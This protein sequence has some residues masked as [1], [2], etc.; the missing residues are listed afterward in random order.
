MSDVNFANLHCYVNVNKG[1]EF[2]GAW[3]FWEVECIGGQMCHEPG[4]VMI[5]RPAPPET[6]SSDERR[7][8][9]AYRLEMLIGT[10]SDNDDIM[11]H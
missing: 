2:E 3:P 7:R 1:E 6:R 4:S 11:K 10:L 5:G 9:G 8:K